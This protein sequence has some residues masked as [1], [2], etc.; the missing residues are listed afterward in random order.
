MTIEKS[1]SSSSRTRIYDHA[2]QGP[3]EALLVPAQAL[4]R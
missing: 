1:R 4:E 2:A 3:V